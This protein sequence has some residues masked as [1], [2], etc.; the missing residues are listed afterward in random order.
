MDKRKDDQEK[1]AAQKAA[2]E[3]SGQAPLP[4]NRAFS[5]APRIEMGENLRQQLEEVVTA[6]T[7]WNINEIQLKAGEKAIIEAELAQS[8][9]RAAHV[10]EALDYTG[11]REET[12]EWLLIHVP[13]DDL[14]RWAMPSKYTAGVSLV[15][16]NP[17]KDAQIRR[18]TRGGYSTDLCNQAL[19]D[20]NGNELEALEALQSALVPPKPADGSTLGLDLDIW[21]E[22]VAALEA[23]QGESFH[24]NGLGSCSIKL[25]QHTHPVVAVHLHK[26]KSGYPET[27]VPLLMI[28]AELPA[29]VRLSATRQCLHHAWNSLLGDQMLFGM[30]EWLES[31]LADVMADPGR[32]VDV[33]VEA[34]DLNLQRVSSAQAVKGK[35]AI[36]RSAPRSMPR[37]NRSGQELKKIW[38]ARQATPEQQ[39][40]L[41]ARQSL[42]AW[43]KR[44][45]VVDA[46]KDKQVTLITGETGSGKST[47]SLQFVLDDAIANGQGSVCN[48]I[49]T[50]PRRVAALSLADRV[51]AE[52]CVAE[53]DEV[54]YVIRGASK[55]SVR[56]RITFMTTGVLLRRLQLSKSPQAALEGISHVFVDEVHE[57]SLDTDFLLSLLKD[58]MKTTNLKIVLMSATVDA[59]VFSNY[60]GGAGKVAR[61]H[62]EGRTYPVEDVYLDNVLRLTGYVSQSHRQDDEYDQA[63]GKAI[64]ELGSGVN[65]ELIASLIRQIDDQLGADPGGILIFLPGT[66]EIE[67]CLRAVSNIPRVHALPLHASL[68]PAEQKRVFPPAPRGTRKVICATNVAETSITISDIVAVIDTGRVKE[69]A[70][71]VGSNI[72]RLQEVWASRA[73][74]KQRRGRAGRVQAGTNYKLYTKNI[75][76]SMRSAAEPEMQRVPLEQLCLNVKAT[77]PTND[78]ATFLKGVISPP[79][80]SAVANALIRLHRMGALEN[81]HLTGLGT[82]MSML[83]TDLRCAKLVIYGTIF[84][85]LET[86]LTIASILTVKSPFVSPRDKRAE[87]DAARATF[88]TS[89]GDLLLDTAAFTEWKANLPRL[90]NRDLHQWCT[91]NFLSQATLRDI[92]STRSQLL[93]ALKESALVPTTYSTRNTSSNDFTSLNTQTSNRPL[94]RALIA[95]ALSPN[96]AEI[97]F[98]DKKFIASMSGAKELDPE[99]RTI[100]FFTEP[101]STSINAL[102][103]ASS[104]TDVAPPRGDRAFIHPS[105]SLFTAQ[106]FTS[107]AAYLSYFTRVAT[108]KTFIRDLTPLNAYALLLFGGKLE[109]DPTGAGV[110]VD[111]WVRMRGWARIGVLVGRLRGCLDEGLRGRVDEERGLKEGEFERVVG[112]V[113]RLLELNGQDQ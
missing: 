80:S 33:D 20:N 101:F 94:L 105:S 49:C 99:A 78:P 4:Q 66:L 35:G 50:Q 25:Q 42:P 100:K 89:D 21:D 47:Q 91:A 28:E 30:I 10:R 112:L 87:A 14:P 9:F 32:L 59:D 110:V 15:S 43:N 51:S 48:M 13:E 67:R 54:G 22:E 7:V 5:K 92:D 75:E 97:K 46:I 56:T 108:S 45:E 90:S 27:A 85:C 111:G 36:R 76:T 2:L 41:Q 93:D 84:S 65:Y 53:G 29:H 106:S 79:D 70:Y 17:A 73:Q 44:H 8:G 61:A 71:D 55:T 12:L 113:R 72:V 77:S 60:F 64:Q 83:P 96:I 88:S 37:D 103:Q 3:A 57:R 31:N 69:T 62:I 39:T 107:H 109:V 58:V 24:Q 68:L 52:R 1:K 95:G 26:P 86:T 34:A 40:M 104:N 16:S 82:Y 6:N 74:C 98:P 102:P 11:S 18:L 23:I 19:R 38:D 81:N 63:V